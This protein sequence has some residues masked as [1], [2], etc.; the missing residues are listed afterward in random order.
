M[1]Q[2]LT[3][4][5]GRY[6]LDA[7]LWPLPVHHARLSKTGDFDPGT[8]LPTLEPTLG[9]IVT[10]GS[11]LIA[12]QQAGHFIPELPRR[13]NSGFKKFYRSLGTDLHCAG[14]RANRAALHPRIGV[15]AGHAPH[16]QALESE[17]CRCPNDG[18]AIHGL[19]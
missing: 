13:F 15:I 3:T 18:H 8:N 1:P 10:C 2:T 7:D 16:A 17:Q 6:P 14:K 12:G 5:T 9:L 19:E 4:K 11:Q